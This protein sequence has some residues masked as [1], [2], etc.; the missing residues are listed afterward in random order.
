MSNSEPLSI[1]TDFARWHASIDIADDAT[2]CQSRWS[3]VSAVVQAADSKEVE[4][5]IRLSFKS[6]QSANAVQVQKIR[7]AFKIADPA[8]G[9]AGQ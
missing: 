3:G 6:R 5:L 1:H 4:A 8:F 7:Q 2:R 9:Y